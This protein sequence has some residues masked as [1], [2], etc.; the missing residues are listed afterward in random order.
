MRRRNRL[1]ALIVASSLCGVGWTAPVWAGKKEPLKLVKRKDRPGKQLFKAAYGKGGRLGAF[2]DVDADGHLEFVSLHRAE[3]R[4]RLDVLE[5]DSDR[6]SLDVGVGDGLPAGLVALNLDDDEPL[7]F[8]VGSGSRAQAR[9]KKAV[10]MFASVVGAV[11]AVN[12]QFQAGASHAYYVVVVPGVGTDLYD[13]AAF[14]HDGSRLWHR[15]F[16]AEAKGDVTWGNTR[17]R[18]VVPPSDGS[19]GAVLITDDARQA[20]VALSTRDGSTLWTRRLDGGVRASK[21]NFNTMVDGDRL[22]PALYSSERVLI[23]DPRNGEPILKKT[24]QTRIG[25]LPSWQVFGREDSKGFLVFGEG[26][27]ELRMVALESGEVRWSHTMEK[28]RDVLPTRN[29]QRFIAVWKHG[30]KIFDVEGKLVSERA[31]PAKIKT[32]FSPVYRDLDGDGVLEF[33]FVSGKKIM[34]WN[35]LEDEVLWTVGLGGMVGAA[36]PVGLHDAFYDLDG[37]GWLDVPAKKGS[38][39][40]KWISGRSGQ[41]LASVGNGINAPV[42]GDWDGDGRPEVFWWKSWYDAV[43]AR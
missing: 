16:Q 4:L 29:G 30:I 39:S 20:V 42:A 37:D 11:V 40:G 25:T 35:P 26:K 43:P 10:V 15:D 32:V 2:H 31:A 34:C 1:T 23:L 22:L 7:E 9:I 3:D 28:V 12:V 21:R 19:G 5:L 36:N 33:V 24:L 18:F 14:D 17:F 27:D 41:V 13:L 38:G 8:V 6:E